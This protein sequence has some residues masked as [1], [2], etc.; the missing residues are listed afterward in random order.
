MKQA[1]H[2]TYHTDAVI[3]CG[4]GASIVTGSTRKTTSVEICANCHPLYTGEKKRLDTTG[5]V[6]R[7]EKLSKKAQEKAT[8]RSKREKRSE[9]SRK[10]AEKTATPST[11]PVSASPKK[12]AKKQEENQ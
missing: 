9:K 10:K 8:L 3:T 4:C 7:F 1:I 6:D 11:Q 5:R 2:P 12:T